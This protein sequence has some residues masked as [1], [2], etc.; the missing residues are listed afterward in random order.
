MTTFYG[1]PLHHLTTVADLAATVAAPSDL[2]EFAF[3]PKVQW[4]SRAFVCLGCDEPIHERPGQTNHWYIDGA[5]PYCPPCVGRG[6]PQPD[7]FIVVDVSDARSA[8]PRPTR[9]PGEARVL[10]H[11]EALHHSLQTKF[12]PKT[13][14][15]LTPYGRQPALHTINFPNRHVELSWLVQTQRQDLATL[16]E[17][18]RTNGLDSVNFSAPSDDGD[19][20]MEAAIADDDVSRTH[21]GYGVKGKDEDGRDTYY[22]LDEVVAIKRQID[23]EDFIEGCGTSLRIYAKITPEGRTITAEYMSPKRVSEPA[24]TTDM[25]KQHVSTLRRLIGARS[26][27]DILHDRERA[28]YYGKLVW[29]RMTPEQQLAWTRRDRRALA[30]LGIAD[31]NSSRVLFNDPEPPR[32][33]GPVEL[34]LHEAEN[35]LEPSEFD[36]WPMTDEE[37]LNGLPEDPGYATWS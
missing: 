29:A 26:N 2:P 11:T 22:N 32:E 18:M 27:E 15:F 23:W 37:F 8:Y 5:G 14:G 6:T 36:L 3:S 19:S 33:G 24:P 4:L 31:D 17:E 12:A 13:E 25:L 30:Y 28:Y 10:T 1:P 7:T 20:E 16:H 35:P 21:Y 9:T 34:G